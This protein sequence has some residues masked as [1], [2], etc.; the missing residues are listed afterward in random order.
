MGQ[1]SIKAAPI[2]TP[3]DAPEGYEF[4]IDI[5]RPAGPLRYR[6]LPQGP[7]Q[8]GPLPLSHH[9]PEPAKTPLYARKPRD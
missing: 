5:S 4:E 9:T 3:L 2:W 8:Q 7:W 6:I 1:N